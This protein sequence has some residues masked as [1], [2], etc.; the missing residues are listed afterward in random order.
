M[1]GGKEAGAP[2]VSAPEVWEDVETVNSIAECI[3][4]GAKGAT[5]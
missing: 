4:K 3:R 1:C 5:Y 2:G